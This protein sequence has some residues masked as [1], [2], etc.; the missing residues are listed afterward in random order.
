MIGGLYNPPHPCPLAAV[1]R[2][3]NAYAGRQVTCHIE[4]LLN[5]VLP[6]IYLPGSI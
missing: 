1:G 5:L 2:A 4:D 6:L 3:A